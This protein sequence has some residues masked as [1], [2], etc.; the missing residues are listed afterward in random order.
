M[1]STN[2][3]SSSDGGWTP[4]PWTVEGPLRPGR[5]YR[6]SSPRGLVTYVGDP[7]TFTSDRANASLIAAAP[8]LAEALEEL[9]RECIAAAEREGTTW[10]LSGPARDLDNKCR[11][12][13][14]KARGEA[15]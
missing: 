7:V 12:A 2:Q 10:P 9:H 8:D 15:A 1:T 13:L 6:I 5:T 4:G 3:T 14:R 11:A